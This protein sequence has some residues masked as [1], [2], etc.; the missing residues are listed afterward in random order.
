MVN[1]SLTDEEIN[2]FLFCMALD[3][4]DECILDAC[5]ESANPEF[6][7]ELVRVGVTFPYSEARWQMAELLRGNIPHKTQYLLM[8]LADSDRYVRKRANNVFQEN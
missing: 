1:A 2:T 5:K 7:S 4:E 8:L 3:S 6:L